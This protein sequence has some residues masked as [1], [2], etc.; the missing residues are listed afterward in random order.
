MKKLLVL[1]VLVLVPVLVKAEFKAPT[2]KQI[3]QV[4]ATPAQITSLLKD[5]SR[6]QATDVVLRAVRAVEKSDLKPEEKKERVAQIFAAVQG[7]MGKDSLLVLGDVARRINPLLLPAVA[8]PGAGVVAPAGLPIALPL[9]PPVAT[10]YS[11]Q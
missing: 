11:G 5:A 2:D 4:V 8:A 9:A 3:Q 10:R 1:V 7:A 6:A